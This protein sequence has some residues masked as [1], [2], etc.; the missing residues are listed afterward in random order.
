VC[1][2]FGEIPTRRN[3]SGVGARTPIATSTTCLVMVFA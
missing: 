1:I 2:G 3:L